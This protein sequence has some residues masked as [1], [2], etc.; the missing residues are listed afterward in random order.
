MYPKQEKTTITFADVIMR[1]PDG[2]SARKF[3]E[4]IRWNGNVVCP[5]CGSVHVTGRK[6]D[7]EG[8]YW[9]NDCKKEFTVRTN[10]IMERSHIPLNKWIWT[11]YK[12]VTERQGVSALEISKEVG[13]SQHA[14]WYLLQRI[15]MAAGNGDK[16]LNGIVEADETYIGGK[17]RNKHSKKKSHAGRGAAGKTAVFGLVE[18]NGRVVARVVDN[19]KADTLFNWFE[20]YVE[21]SATVYTDEFTSYDNL[22]NIGYEHDNVN[23]SAGNYVKDGNIH[24]NTIESVWSVLKRSIVGTYHSVSVKHLQKYV[25]ETTFRL[26]EG[27]C[28]VK[29]VDRM[30][31][32][33]AKTFGIV[34]RYKVLIGTHFFESGLIAEN[35]KL[36]EARGFSICECAVTAD[37]SWK[38]EVARIAA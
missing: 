28:D 36:L 18:R 14:A 22:H 24:T 31:A 25:D 6:G 3:I 21:K 9:C 26:N 7:R 13:V 17:E 37:D 15:R 29:T 23:H 33:I 27:R 32:L 11:I 16:L 35:N 38:K 20:K 30:E 10:T 5:L 4:R 1:F 8:Y 2:N 12:F 19:T 34:T